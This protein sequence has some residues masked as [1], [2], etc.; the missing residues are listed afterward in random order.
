MTAVDLPP[1]VGVADRQATATCVFAVRHDGG[2]DLAGV[3]GHEDGG[4]LDLL[5]LPGTGLAAVVQAVPA[6]E[7]T[8]EALR[9]RLSDPRTLESCARAHHAV[10]TAAAAGGPVVPLPLAT[11]FT[12]PGS[13]VAALAEQ[14]SRFLAV[15]DRVKGRAEWAVK[16]HVTTV[17]RAP[18]AAPDD[19]AAAGR[20]GAGAAY[21]AR[22]RG[23]ERDR[24]ARQDA[25]RQE[26]DHVHQVAAAFAAGAVR[27]PPH[28]TAITG[29]NRRQILNSAFL[30]DDGRAADLVAAV[31]A[32]SGTRAGL[33]V[34]VDVSGPWVPYSFTGDDDRDG[35]GTGR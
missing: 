2:P 4:P 24:Q 11:L 21:L 9:R 1:L 7:F 19:A 32:L 5:V 14:R 25:I 33:D 35:Q 27:R 12:G 30:V 16:V 28:G 3:R 10:I 22:V 34:Q 29:E 23:R 8:Q 26:G 17:D 6:A 31:R 13:A 15:L 18:E 20:P